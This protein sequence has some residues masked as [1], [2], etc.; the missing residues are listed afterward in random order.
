MSLKCYYNESYGF[1]ENWHGFL[2]E[3][4][5]E[6]PD[7]VAAAAEQAE[8]E[9][10]RAQQ[11]EQALLSVGPQLG[12]FLSMIKKLGPLNTNAAKASIAAV[13]GEIDDLATQEDSV[14][15]FL[16]DLGGAI[17]LTGTKLQRNM[18]KQG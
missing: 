10:M 13:F 15:V 18:P 17:N 14:E 3:Q 16:N 1:F 6:D 8:A 9:A 2:N 12:Q 7:A 5:G 11:E 4:T